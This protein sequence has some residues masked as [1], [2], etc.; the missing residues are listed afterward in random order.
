MERFPRNAEN[1]DGDRNPSIRLFGRRFSNDLQTMNALAELLLVAASDKEVLSDS[2]TSFT[3]TGFFPDADGLRALRENAA[4]LAYYPKAR[5]NLKLF[6]FLGASSLTTRYR[7]HQEH[8]RELRRLLGE[9][10]DAPAGVEPQTVLQTLSALFL[11]FLGNGAGRTWSAQ[12]FLPFHPSLL[13]CETIC[14]KDTRRLPVDQWDVAIRQHCDFS[15]HE[16]F[17]RSGES[18]YLQLCNAFSRTKEEVSAWLEERKDIKQALRTEVTDPTALAAAL[19]KA[20]KN[21]LSSAPAGLEPVLKFVDTG[22]DRNTAEA[23]DGT[24]E[25]PRRAECGWIPAESWR[26]GYLFAVET[27]RLL[28]SKLDPM[29]ALDLL[30]VA[31]SLQI[32]RTLVRQACRHSG[33][34]ELRLLLC[35]AGGDSRKRKA[36]SGRSLQ[37]IAKTLKLAIRAPDIRNAVLETERRRGAADP[38]GELDKDYREGDAY[39][40]GLHR[41]IGKS[42]GLIVPPKG[43]MKATLNERLL[44]CL[45][46]TLVPEK[47]TT[48]DSFKARLEAHHGFVFDPPGGGEGDAWLERILEA[49]GMLVRLSDACSLVR[50]PFAPQD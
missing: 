22:V 13:C 29:E 23:S 34:G 21:F 14:K 41:K 4:G 43:V 38:E 24:E 26:E 15:K 5:L 17:D 3:T 48:L 49:A 16:I 11:G 31:C 35:D 33:T 28:S 39:G 46:L 47:R 30:E 20:L 12:T 19:S 44:R 18:L 7:V 2:G 10:I 27:T 37:E 6:S 25:N 42:I 50:N 9:R 1:G 45:V 36:L 8:A 40:C 32:M